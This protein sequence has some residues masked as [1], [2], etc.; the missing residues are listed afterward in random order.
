MVA[1]Y[2]SETLA[3]RL[4]IKTNINH[5]TITEIV[6]SVQG[7][8]LTFQGCSNISFIKLL[9]SHLGLAASTS[10]PC[11]CEKFKSNKNIPS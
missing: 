8:N 3:N 10:E 9:S 6:T 2:P 11:V 5:N 4:L 1:A 7:Y